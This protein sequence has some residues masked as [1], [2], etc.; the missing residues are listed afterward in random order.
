MPPFILDTFLPR[1]ERGDWGVRWPIHAFCVKNTSRHKRAANILIKYSMYQYKLSLYSD[2][3]KSNENSQKWINYF[4]S[5]FRTKLQILKVNFEPIWVKVEAQLKDTTSTSLTKMRLLSLFLFFPLSF[6]N[7]AMWMQSGT[8]S[9]QPI[10]PYT[11][12]L[13]SKVF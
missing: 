7:K 9:P 6:Y 4:I 5:S 13:S 10:W 2:N 1:P 12:Q 8:S 11:H 3:R